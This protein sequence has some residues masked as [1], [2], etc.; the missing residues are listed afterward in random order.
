VSPLWYTRP[1]GPS[2]NDLLWNIV[3]EDGRVT[4]VYG[5]IWLD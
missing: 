4:R 2:E 3:I 5:Q 1:I